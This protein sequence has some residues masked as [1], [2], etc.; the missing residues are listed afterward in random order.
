MNKI[1]SIFL[2]FVFFTNAFSAVTTRNGSFADTI[3][4]TTVNQ[5]SGTVSG[6]ETISGSFAQAAPGSLDATFGS[7]GIVLSDVG[8]VNKILFQNDG[9]IIVVGESPESSAIIAR[10]NANGRLDSGF[11][12]GGKIILRP[13]SSSLD[14]TDA[15]LQS[16][17]KI[18]AVSFQYNSSFNVHRYNSDGTPDTGF[19]DGGTVRTYQGQAGATLAVAIQ[20]DGKILVGGASGVSKS[21]GLSLNRYNS[22][23]SFDTNLYTIGVGFEAVS[24]ILVQPDGKILISSSGRIRRLNPNGTLDTTFGNNGVIDSQINRVGKVTLALQPDGKIVVAGSK[25]VSDGNITRNDFA[26]AR[27]NAD[28]TPDLSFGTNGVVQTKIGNSNSVAV[29]V[30]IQKNGK[31]VAIGGNYTNSNSITISFVTV[32]YTAS[33]SLDTGFGNG[34][35]ETLAAS[36]RADA[37]AIQPDGK[38]VVAGLSGNDPI[39]ARYLGDAVNSTP[40]FDFDGDGRADISVFRPSNGVWYFLN[41]LNGFSAMKFGLS[42]DQIA[43]ADFD[44]DRKTD[45]AVFRPSNGEWTVLNSSDNT[46]RV[47][48]FG[49]TGDVPRPGDFDGDG[50]ADIAVFRPSNG[51]WYW[52][53]SSDGHFRFAQFGQNGDVPLL[54]DFDNDGK[55]DLAVYRPTNSVWYWLQ[56]SDQSFKAFH[57]GLMEDIPVPAD[58]DG[59]GKSDIAIFRP[60]NGFWSVNRSLLGFTSVQFGDKSDK[61]VA[62][63]YDGDG[64]ADISVYRPSNG[65]WY[66]LQSASGSFNAVQFGVA[67]DKP[68][69]FTSAP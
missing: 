38:I 9:K 56:S 31:I 44:G 49:T 69:P 64:R 39:L 53:Q 11:G 14:F 52:L 51:Y 4:K 40:R 6:N 36:G 2:V 55:S 41:S 1:F 68:I 43:P 22:D 48:N 67:S 65:V 45:I 35:I 42:Q 21:P 60:S 23:G 26:V 58:Y 15:A 20:N 16:D 32:R 8:I 61:P 57:F 28:G 50:K 13:G 10:Y 29:D 12:V 25:T 17:G 33:G 7:G 30:A 62:A 18:V 19:G 3:R 63:D 34:G 37:V 27:F 47:L 5:F 59:D 66:S 24:K 46:Y 54:A